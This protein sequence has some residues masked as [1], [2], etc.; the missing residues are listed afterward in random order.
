MKKLLLFIIAGVLCATNICAQTI[1]P[2]IPNGTCG[3]IGP[4]GNNLTWRLTTDGILTISGNGYMNDWCACMTSSGEI[5]YA[6][7]Y[8]YKSRIL[9]VVINNGVSAIGANAFY[10]LSSLISV[11]MPET[12]VEIGNRAFS[13]CSSLTSIELPESVIEIGYG[14]FERCSSLTNIM[15]PESVTDIGS[16]AF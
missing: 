6:P 15:I 9:Q 1:V 4:N 7:W 5:D 2:V 11:E 10:G 14:A 12:I 3:N 13:N 8:P 16:S